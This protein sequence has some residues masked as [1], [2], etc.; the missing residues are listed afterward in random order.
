MV[1][2]APGAFPRPR[3]LWGV[4]RTSYVSRQRTLM[5]VPPDTSGLRRRLKNKMSMQKIEKTIF[6]GN[7]AI[8]EK[9]LKIFKML[10]SKKNDLT[11]FQIKIFE[12]GKK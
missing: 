5:V 8:F 7:F 10:L 6:I 4:A 3:G 1:R 11:F 2:D 9:F 12:L